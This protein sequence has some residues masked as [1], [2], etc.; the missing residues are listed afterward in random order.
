MPSGKSTGTVTRLRT[1]LVCSVFVLARVQARKVNRREAM[2]LHIVAPAIRNRRRLGACLVEDS[3]TEIVVAA[4]DVQGAVEAWL[5]YVSV[6]RQLAANTSEAYR[7]DIAQ[8]L[9]ILARH[10]NRLPNIPQLAALS[11]RD[12]RAFLAFRRAEG[13]GSRSLS[14]SLSAL[15]MFFRFLERRGLGKNDAVRAVA[16]P[17]LAHSVPKP[18]TAPKA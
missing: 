7:R 18:L 9:G 13:V 2:D 8:F 11:A 17:K 4:G 3:K 1:G 6:E 10:L 16:L 12:F 14:R 15:R 5:T